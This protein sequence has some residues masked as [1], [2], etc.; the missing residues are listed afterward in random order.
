MNQTGLKSDDRE[1]S[2]SSKAPGVR[3][4]QAILLLAGALF[5][6]FVVA[7][8]AERFYWTPLTIGLAFLGAAIAG[9]RDGGHWATACV[10]TGWGAVVVLAG[11]ARPDL[12]VSGLYLVGAGL[13]AVA[14]L[15]LQRA[16]FSV[17]TMALA[18]AITG[19]G[20]ALALTTQAPG[21]LDDATTYAVAIGV[22]ALVNV[23]L[24]AVQRAR[25]DAPTPDANLE[26]EVT[27]DRA[28]S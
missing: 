17:D 4:N 16:G 8:E 12:D 10:L 22:V 1:W 21:V 9:G 27:Y 15:L 18:L 7:P 24:A 6:V 26:R 20:L 19:G 5:L 23:V 3:L 2:M 14:G 25:P 11:A 13:G 28:S